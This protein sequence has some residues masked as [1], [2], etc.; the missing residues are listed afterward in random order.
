[1]AIIYGITI[2]AEGI[3]DKDQL[4]ILEIEGCDKYQGYYFSKPVDNAQINTL[5]LN[6][7]SACNTHAIS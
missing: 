2:T 4:N 5:L 6:Q 1:M 3:E 7:R